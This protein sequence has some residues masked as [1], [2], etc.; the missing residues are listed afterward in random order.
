M[1]SEEPSSRKT[2]VG[3]RYVGLLVSVQL[4]MSAPDMRMMSRT[5]EPEGPMMKPAASS[6]TRAMMPPARGRGAG[7][8]GGS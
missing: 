2:R 3:R 7:V 6:V 8:E 4:L 1:V 5:E